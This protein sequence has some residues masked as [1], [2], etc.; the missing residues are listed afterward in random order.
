L[1]NAQ[2]KVAAL[3]AISLPASRCFY[4]LR[5]KILDK[6]LSANRT[7]GNLL[8]TTLRHF[9]PVTGSFSQFPEARLKTGAK[10]TFQIVPK[11]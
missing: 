10:I 4:W 8:V 7:E 2:I 6:K 9:S 11:I 1:G 3:W 5:M